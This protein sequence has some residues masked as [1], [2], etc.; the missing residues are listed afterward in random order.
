MV[1]NGLHGEI[2]YPDTE[3]GVGHREAITE[4]ALAHERQ[5]GTTVSVRRTDSTE[6]QIG[7]GCDNT[8]LG[9]P[10]NRRRIIIAAMDA[11]DT[12]AGVRPPL[13]SAHIRG[14]HRRCSAC[15]RG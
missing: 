5:R 3:G 14:T 1:K 6:G 2:S 12:P 8:E 4:H 9:F 15:F 10:N 11:V 7:L 13:R